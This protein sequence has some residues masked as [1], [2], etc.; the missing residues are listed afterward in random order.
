MWLA[1]LDGMVRFDG[2]KFTVFNK[3]NSQ[4]IESN[5]FT[6]SIIDRSNTLWIGTENGVVTRYRKRMWIGTVNAEVFSLENEKLI[7]HPIESEQPLND[8]SDKIED[9]EALGNVTSGSDNDFE[10]WRDNACYRQT[11]VVREFAD[12]SVWG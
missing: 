6:L 9:R 11:R 3:N 5:R 2:V 8:A 4:G 10:N 12:L 7:A 1:T